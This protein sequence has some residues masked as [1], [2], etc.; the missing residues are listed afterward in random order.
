M[1]QIKE[2]EIRGQLLQKLR[3]VNSDPTSLLLEEFVVGDCRVDVAFLSDRMNAYEIKSDSDNLKRLP[4]QVGVYGL[5]FDSVT[6]VTTNRHVDA[7]LDI[8]PLWWGLWIARRDGAFVAFQRYREP[9]DNPAPDKV[10]LIRMLWGDELRGLLK[11]RGIGTRHYRM[12]YPSLVMLAFESLSIFDLTSIVL[13]R[14]KKR[15]D[16]IA[17]GRDRRKKAKRINDMAEK[18]ERKN[19]EAFARAVEEHKKRM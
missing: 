13:E 5:H 17:A 12:A 2:G 9:I 11:E 4:A 16:W 10:S 8:I 3:G 6:L 15:G 7:A 18:R 1:S 19:A 14:L